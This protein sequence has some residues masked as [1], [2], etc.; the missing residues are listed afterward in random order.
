MN[1]LVIADEPVLGAAWKYL[2]EERGY[3]VLL[4]TNGVEGIE[5]GKLT[6]PDLVIFDADGMLGMGQGLATIENVKKALPEVQILVLASWSLDREESL[7]RGATVCVS[8]PVDYGTVLR[9]ADMMVTR[10]TS[11]RWPTLAEETALPK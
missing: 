7:A 2:L 3:K 5:I 9:L 1:I 6:P 10:T 4:T 11:R 8:K